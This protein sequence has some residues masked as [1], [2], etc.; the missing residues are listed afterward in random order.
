MKSWA[1]FCSGVHKCA[2]AIDDHFLH[3][4]AIR[5]NTRLFSTFTDSN[6]ARISNQ[7]Q[8]YLKFQVNFVVFQSELYTDYF[9]MS[10]L[11]VVQLG[12]KLLPGPLTGL[13]GC[14]RALQAALG[15]PQAL[16]KLSGVGGA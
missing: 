4:R 14:V 3:A 2:R 10:P 7:W 5:M 12:F 16:L 15:L 6:F 9:F 13:V 8:S 1:L 11:V